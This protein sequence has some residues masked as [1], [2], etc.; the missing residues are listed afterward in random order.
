M[1]LGLLFTLLLLFTTPATAAYKW[2]APDG[3][4]S[5]SD[6]PPHP[7]AEQV[8]LP[9][10]QTFAP[11]PIAPQKPDTKPDPEK[12]VA[13]Y[14]SITIIQPAHDASIRDNPGNISITVSASPKLRIKRGHKITIELDGAVMVTTTSGFATLANIDRGTHTLRATIVDGDGTAL[15]SSAVSTFHLHRASSHR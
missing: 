3:S 2:L 4:V 11:P 9:S 8:T 13:L 10:A 7:D 12:N 6:S 5:F 14:N 15:I 1:R